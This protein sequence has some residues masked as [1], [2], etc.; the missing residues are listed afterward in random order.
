MRVM[1]P[2]DTDRHGLCLSPYGK[3]LY[4]SFI[5]RLKLENKIANYLS[6][7][8]QVLLNKAGRMHMPSS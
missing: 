7:T 5:Q 1:R 8:V 6:K 4:K 2:F 3:L